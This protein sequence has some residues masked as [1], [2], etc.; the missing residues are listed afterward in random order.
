M[1]KLDKKDYKILYELDL[2]CRQTINEIAR[3]TQLSR[4]VTRYRIKRL[5]DKGIIQDY[6]TLIDFTKLDY[7]IFRLYLK[8]QNITKDIKKEI[9]NHAKKQ[10]EV[11]ILFETTGEYDLAMGILSENIIDYQRV[12][13][14]I[15]SQFKQFVSE[16][17][18]ST[19][20]DYVNYPR[21]YLVSKENRKENTIS[22]MSFNKYHYDEQDLILLKE[23]SHNSKAS[24]LELSKK[25][26]MSVQGV[27]N[28]L[29]RL[30]KEKVIVGYKV[31]LNFDL[32]GYNY[33]KI[34]LELEDLNLIP[35]LKEFITKHPN[36]IYRNITIGGSDFE[37]DCEVK[38][39]QE[40]LQIIGEIRELCD[41]KLRK[42]FYYKSLKIHK[43]TFFPGQLEKEKINH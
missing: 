18:F 1:I 22:T 3:K 10:K 20:E 11:I 7:Q 39:E 26:S 4:D 12:Y 13:K 40:F 25:C 38:N 30:E 23:I 16:K 5:E 8:L 15:I 21:N 6:T 24:L 34:D 33:Y 27:K 29:K 17:R 42:Y 32:L 28:K 2:N 19:F 9:I 35:K 36:I 14:K 37:F 43:Y 31:L 41:G